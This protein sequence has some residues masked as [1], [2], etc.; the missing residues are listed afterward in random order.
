LPDLRSSE[1]G[2]LLV[3]VAVEIPKRITSEQ[4]RLLREFAQI[5][6]KQ[7]DSEAKVFLRRSKNT[8]ADKG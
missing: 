5:E 1:K 6:E 3:Q 8:L 2:D 7:V 4:E